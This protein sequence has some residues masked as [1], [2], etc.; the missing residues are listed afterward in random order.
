MAKDDR[1]SDNI[2]GYSMKD[3][4]KLNKLAHFYGVE[5]I[6]GQGYD[7]SETNHMEK[8]VTGRPGSH[9]GLSGAK[10]HRTHEDLGRDINDKMANGAMGNYLLYSGKNLPHATDVEGL[11]K[12][13][14]DAKKLHKE[15]GGNNYNNAG[16]DNFKLASHAFKEWESNLKNSLSKNDDDSSTE[17]EAPSTRMSWNEAVASG[18]LSQDVQD[19]VNRLENNDYVKFQG[20]KATNNEPTDT[21]A[22]QAQAHLK[23]EVLKLAGD[24]S[25]IQKSKDTERAYGGM[26]G[27][28]SGD[29]HRSLYGGKP[30]AGKNALLDMLNANSIMNAQNYKQT[31]GLSNRSQAMALDNMSAAAGLDFGVQSAM[32]G[33]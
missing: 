22:S 33:F 6:R 31:L 17:E 2:F 8:P 9:G 3:R 20:T 23:N 13:H 32:R 27:L 15:I 7:G 1:D 10:E 11:Y 12:L 14:K 26:T 5:G 16:S 4:K 30:S 25:K 24:K 28:A 21:P 18:T 19:A 29:A